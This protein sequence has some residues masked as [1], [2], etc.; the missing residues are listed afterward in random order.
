[1][2]TTKTTSAAPAIPGVSYIEWS[3]IIG[4]TVLALAISLILAQFSSLFGLEVFSPE[5]GDDKTRWMVILTCIWLFWMQLISSMAGGYLAGRMRAP[6]ADVTND[7]AEVRDGTHGLLVWALG[8]VI[9]VAAAAVGSFWASLVQ[10]PADIA[11]H[12]EIAENLTKNAGIIFGFSTAAG[13]FVSAAAACYM[14]IR[15][16]NHRDEHARF[17]LRRRK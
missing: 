9:A 15:G 6:I 16:G 3:S 17:Q 14:A 4:G 5:Q 12:K 1:M 2:A 10:V 11:Q 8:T 7:E 13:S